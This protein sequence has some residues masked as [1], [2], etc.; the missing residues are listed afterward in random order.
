MLEANPDVQVQADSVL[1]VGAATVSP[2][3]GM[4]DPGCQPEDMSGTAKICR[5]LCVK[6]SRRS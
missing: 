6:N 1:S 4:P 5:L 2:L 3:A